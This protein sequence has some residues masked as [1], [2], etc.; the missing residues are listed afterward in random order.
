MKSI[1]ALVLLVPAALLF[2]SSAYLSLYPSSGSAVTR[3]P[4]SHL[5]AGHPASSSLVSEAHE[6][7]RRRALQQGPDE[8]CYTT[9]APDSNTDPEPRAPRRSAGPLQLQH[10]Q[11]P[12]VSD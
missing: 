7:I 11:V 5:R 6:G 1:S 3:A 9:S 8:T 12:P 10:I 2:P 4:S